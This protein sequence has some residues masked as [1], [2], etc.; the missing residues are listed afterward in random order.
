M[1]EAVDLDGSGSIDFEE[2]LQVII[3]KQ[4]SSRDLHAEMAGGFQLMDKDG[5]GYIS[6]QVS[7]H[8]DVNSTTLCTNVP[9][10]YN[11]WVLSPAV[12]LP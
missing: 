8:S 12:N 2:F 3:N 1:I 7:Y 6:L 10:Q 5:D 9:Y 4:G 11:W